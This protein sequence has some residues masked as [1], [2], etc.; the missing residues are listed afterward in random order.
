MSPP[1]PDADALRPGRKWLQCFALTAVLLA[2]FLATATPVYESGDDAAMMQIVSGLMTGEPSDRLVFTNVFIGKVLSTLYTWNQSIDW[3]SL[4]LMGVHL[5]SSAARLFAFVSHRVDRSAWMAG[6]LLFA[7]FEVRMLLEFQFTSTALMAGVAGILLL[8][9]G[10]AEGQRRSNFT[11]F[12]GVALLVLSAMIRVQAFQFA[13]LISAP[14]VALDI[15]R[16]KRESGG[17]PSRWGVAPFILAGVVSFGVVVYDASVYAR[18]PEWKA[19]RGVQ[20][21][22]AELYDFPAIEFAPNAQFFFDRVGWTQNDFNMFRHYYLADDEI[23]NERTLRSLQ[24]RF[25]RVARTPSQAREHRE[26]YLW[27]FWPYLLIGTLNGLLSIVLAAGARWRCTLLAVIVW[28][29]IWTI[30]FYFSIYAK[31]ASRVTIPAIYAACAVVFYGALAWRRCSDRAAATE[32]QGSPRFRW[33]AAACMLVV[34][35]GYT[36]GVYQA[37]QLHVLLNAS[38]VAKRN[39]F[40]HLTARIANDLRKET[41]PVLV[42][43]GS[44]YPLNWAGPSFR[45]PAAARELNTIGVGWNVDSPHYHAQLKNAGIENLYRALFERPDV[46]C[47]GSEFD[48]DNMTAYAL[49]HFGEAIDSST[50]RHYLYDERGNIPPGYLR[51]RKLSRVSPDETRQSAAPEENSTR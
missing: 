48:V 34:A 44:E 30:F 20:Q 41:R 31:L 23:A 12:V 39:S 11:T 43:W 9:S 27:A 32:T 33:L 49:E 24:A 6:L 50:P 42:A 13:I 29:F 47:F 14:L 37:T 40:E 5:L 17:A 18:D 51:V 16:W 10:R 25:G 3:Y 2:A 26:Q 15:L 45:T 19:F 35:T 22:R 28:G 7:L 8:L 36:I 4:Y 21:I 38:N 46:Y 1:L